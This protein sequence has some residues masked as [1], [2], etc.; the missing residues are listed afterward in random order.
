MT[1]K[2]PSE[3]NLSTK[4][5]Y[6]RQS[7]YGFQLAPNCDKFSFVSQY[8]KRTTE[9]N[10]SGHPR[11]KDSA[12]ADLFLLPTKGG[13]PQPI[14]SSGDINAPAVWAP[15]GN[16]LAIKS[17]GGLDV[18]DVLNGQRKTIFKGELYEPPV[19][20]GDEYLGY[21]RWSP[22]GFWLAIVTFD[23]P[24]S[25]LRL[26]S[27]DG[28]T[29][30][31]LFSLDGYF[32]SWDW[33]PDSKK[34]LLVTRSEDGWVG[35]IRVVDVSSGDISIFWAEE[36]YEYKKPVAI[37]ALQGD[38]IIFRSNRSGWSKLWRASFDGSQIQPLTVG[39]WDDAAFR[40][41][42]DGKEIVFASQ[43]NQRMGGSDLWLLSL[44]NGE[45][46]RLTS[47]DGA[48]IPIA[49]STDG[50]I[51][52][53]HSSPTE[54]GD[55][56]TISLSDRQVGQLTY[57]TSLELRSKLRA[58][59][60]VTITEDDGTKIPCLV[61][62]PAYFQEE[63]RYPAIV[64]IRGGPTGICRYDFA[65]YYNWLANQGYVVITPNYRGSVGF[66]VSHMKAV[67]GDGLG[68]NDLKD[69]LAAGEY[70]KSLSYVDLSRGIGVGGRSW[71]G[72]LTLMAITHAPEKFSCAVAGAAIADWRIQQSQTEVR[73]YDRWLIGG[74]VYEQA[75]RAVERSPISNL[76]QIKA[77]LFVFHGEEDRDVPF[78]QIENF[79]KK[80]QQVDIQLEYKFY[81]GEG[82][83]NK[84]QENQTDVL[85]RTK[86]F[87][88]RH[89]Q[90]WDFR[91]NPSSGQVQ[92]I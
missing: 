50:Q 46:K 2:Q 37:W 82:H 56:W 14:T 23:P 53:W 29:S 91:D 39:G 8:D 69:V 22:D 67:S 84:K 32:I 90:P 48:N 11:M 68:K 54:R 55:L 5:V 60:E 78:A 88:R 6:S 62:L 59:E 40:L 27:K 18:L 36:N 43:Q 25:T 52:Y 21:P 73:Y 16:N 30:R 89:L 49:W 61:Y 34:I 12:L 77:P 4:D 13:F 45:Q 64:W 86:V 10:A 47:Q 83:S 15:D 9:V 92:Y 51:Y 87:F 28:H 20:L 80:A 75:Q 71:G 70:L 58:P 85:E 33:S 63:Q 19:D 26:V 42:P 17:Q 1:T 24:K 66:G 74:W 65:P 57:S 76:D 3:Y 41:S 35:D 72:Y 31:E 7:I 44:E 79:V 38:K 81:T